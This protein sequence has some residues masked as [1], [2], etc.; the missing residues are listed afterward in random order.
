MGNPIWPRRAS[1]GRSRLSIVADDA[2]AERGQDD[3]ASRM[4]GERQRDGD[5]HPDERRA[6]GRDDRCGAGQQAEGERA[7]DAEDGVRGRRDD[8]LGQRR[9]SGTDEQGASDV[10]ERAH[11]STPRGRVH[12]DAAREPPVQTAPVDDERVERDDEHDDANEHA[13]RRRPDVGDDATDRRAVLPKKVHEGPRL[14]GNRLCRRSRAAKVLERAAYRTR[15]QRPGQQLAQPSRDQKRAGDHRRA[16]REHHEHAQ[17]SRCGSPASQR[18]LESAHQGVHEVGDPCGEHEGRPEQDENDGPRDRQRDQGEA[19]AFLFLSHRGVPA[20]VPRVQATRSETPMAND[21]T[22]GLSS[23]EAERRLAEHGPNELPAAAPDPIWLR[24]LRQFRSPLI[25]VLLFAVVF[26]VADWFY[27]R[28]EGWPVEGTVIGVILLSTRLSAC[29]RSTAR[30]TRSR[31]CRR[32]RRRSRGS[33]ATG[34][35]DGCPAA[36]SCPAISSGSRRA[37]ALP[38]T[39]QVVDGIRPHVR[40]IGADRRVG[41]GRQ[42][43]G[44][45]AAQRHARRARQGVLRASAR[46]A[47]RAPW[48]GSR[49]CLG[50]IKLEKTPLE[51]R[52]D[53]L[54]AQLARWVGALAILL[55]AGGALPR[56]SVALDEVVLFAVALAV[57]AVPERACRRS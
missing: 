14:Q 37:S 29:S 17:C 49:R 57:A 28:L 45:R 33:C 38:A 39:A 23:R 13:R 16:D 32:S 56:D 31:S 30:S 48:G 9:S 52:L 44:A 11:E 5:R 6:H 8:P 7:A 40:R 10:A 18:S 42:G 46:P 43:D 4:A 2:D 51:R 12:R 19:D 24:F 25:Y 34:A 50:A 1:H 41:A 53:T 35:C 3:R 54:G 26:D 20:V 15:A 21:P 47:R 36:S 55:V 27:D 22:E